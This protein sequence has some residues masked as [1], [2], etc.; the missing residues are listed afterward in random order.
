MPRADPQ[1]LPREQQPAG[2]PTASGTPRSHRGWESCAGS[3]KRAGAGSRGLPLTGGGSWAAPRTQHHA[4]SPL[5]ICGTVPS[6]WGAAW[7]WGAPAPAPSPSRGMALGWGAGGAVP[8]WRG[9]R[10]PGVHSERVPGA[11]RHNSLR[12]S[13]SALPRPDKAPRP[14][15]GWA[16]VWVW[17]RFGRGVKAGASARS[18]GH[19]AAVPGS[20]GAPEQRGCRRLAGPPRRLGGEKGGWAAWGTWTLPARSALPGSPAE[21]RDAGP[22]SPRAQCHQCWHSSLAMPV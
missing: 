12:R 13:R 18:H 4:P 22:G 2:T 5:L 9:G 7:L 10:P 19:R 6:G 21:E 17:S 1:P 20:A 16:P 11:H 15:R 3:P 8:G 14:E